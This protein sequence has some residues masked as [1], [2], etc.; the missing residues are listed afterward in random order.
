MKFIPFRVFLIVKKKTNLICTGYVGHPR[1][2][3]LTR[4]LN[5]LIWVNPNR[6]KPD[7]TKL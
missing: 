7:Y 6:L 4:L 3:E 2:K 5:L 1:V